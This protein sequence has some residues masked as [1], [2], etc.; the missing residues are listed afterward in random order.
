MRQ[1]FLTATAL[2]TAFA[3]S[4]CM[5][6]GPAFDMRKV[7]QLVPGQSTEADA[8][9]LLGRP[10]ATSEMADGSQLLQWIFVMGTP[11]GGTGRHVAI[12]FDGGQRMV[13]ITHR[14]EQ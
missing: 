9:Q 10:S 6:M 13:R 12:L 8:V 14:F 7:D 2:G 1:A 3:V 11:V 4:A 5:T